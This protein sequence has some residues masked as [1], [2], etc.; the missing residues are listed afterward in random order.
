[1]LLW[2]WRFAIITLH[3][4][5]TTDTQITDVIVMQSGKLFFGVRVRQTFYF[6]VLVRRAI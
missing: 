3:C 1:M 5:I 6:G 2:L 4:H